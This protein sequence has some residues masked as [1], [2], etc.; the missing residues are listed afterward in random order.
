VSGLTQNERI[1]SLSDPGLPFPA[2]GGSESLSGALDKAPVCQ[3]TEQTGVS[4]SG[5]GA[6]RHTGAAQLSLLEAA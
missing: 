4:S 1:L 2:P 5:A 3:P 6:S